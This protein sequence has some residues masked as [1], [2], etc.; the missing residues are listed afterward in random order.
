MESGFATR[1][2]EVSKVGR[3]DG[4]YTSG[5]GSRDGAVHQRKSSSS[6][7]LGKCL[8]VADASEASLLACPN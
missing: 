3:V 7:Y 6:P 4:G 1:G 2:R 8:R 5:T